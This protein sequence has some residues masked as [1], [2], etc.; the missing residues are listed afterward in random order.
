MQHQQNESVS[1]TFDGFENDNL[2]ISS[3]GIET[4]VSNYFNK[5]IGKFIK[6]LDNLYQQ[7]NQFQNKMNDIEMSVIMLYL[8]DDVVE[9]MKSRIKSLETMTVEKIR[10][11]KEKAKQANE[12]IHKRLKEQNNQIET[13]TTNILIQHLMIEDIFENT[14]TLSNENKELRELIEEE[15]TT[16]Y[17]TLYEKQISFLNK[18]RDIVVNER[19]TTSMSDTEKDEEGNKFGGYVNEKIDKV[20]NTFNDYINDC[21]SF[22]FSLESKGRIEGMM[23]FYIKQQEY[24][25]GSQS[26]DCLFVFGF[27][28]I[29][30]CK[31]NYKT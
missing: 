30:V 24:A 31:E 22:L 29:C 4:L 11:E 3:H 18:S 14:Q 27:G 16:E 2:R 28:D 26:H 7:L 12:F 21:K 9:K 19:N 20:G 13:N 10:K 17:L 15:M 25:F 23:K 6:Q 1:Q 5:H 8:R